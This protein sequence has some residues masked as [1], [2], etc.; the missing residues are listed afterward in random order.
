MSVSEAEPPLKKSTELTYITLG[1]LGSGTEE[2]RQATMEDRNGLD[3]GDSERALSLFIV[4][5]DRCKSSPRPAA[6][7]I[8]G[9]SH[10]TSARALAPKFNTVV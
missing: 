2:K 5:G 3:T 1:R 7:V 6:R 8:L 9:G 10:A 4:T